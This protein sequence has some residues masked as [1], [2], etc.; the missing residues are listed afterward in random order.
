MNRPPNGI[1]A[2]PPF[3]KTHD[4]VKKKF[5]PLLIFDKEMGN[6]QTVSGR[7]K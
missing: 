1:A 3:K 6:E 4:S 7:T 2:D 5:P